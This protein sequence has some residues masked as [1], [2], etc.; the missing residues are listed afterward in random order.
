MMEGA[1][2]ENLGQGRV[3]SASVAHGIRV[4]AEFFLSDLCHTARA[5]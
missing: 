1:S 5:H 3:S 2:E 4:A